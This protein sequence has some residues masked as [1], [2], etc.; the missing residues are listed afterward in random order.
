MT[1]ETHVRDVQLSVADFAALPEEEGYRLEL[2]RGRLVREPAPG[3]AH[4][5]LAGRIY[6]LLWTAAQEGGA[7]H[8]FLDAGF[9]LSTDPPTVRVPD[10]AFVLSDR[11]PRGG[12]P[13]GFGEGAPDLVVEVIS[14]SNRASEMQ[15]KSLE[16]LDAGA[17]LVW[18]VD[19]A[20]GTVA[21]YRSR[22]EIRI[23]AADQVLDG[24]EVLP[25]LEVRVGEL[26]G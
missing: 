11:I 17:H 13:Q 22:S 26:F 12:L 3:L 10:V 20:E 8:V 25:G 14:P 15:R 7:G 9:T 1:T 5:D 16:Y 6:R 18:V 4:S 23:L 21:V 24:G 2:S 19:P